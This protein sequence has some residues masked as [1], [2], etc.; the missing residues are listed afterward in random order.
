M[1]SSEQGLFTKTKKVTASPSFLRD[2]RG[3]G[4]YI[5]SIKLDLTKQKS[6]KSRTGKYSILFK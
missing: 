6:P 5:N 4:G 3:G 1:G 2:V